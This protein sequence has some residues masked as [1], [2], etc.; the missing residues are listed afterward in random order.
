MAEAA[1][2]ALETERRL[3]QL[4]QRHGR[5]AAIQDDKV[6]GIADRHAV[7]HRI[8]QPRQQGRNHIEAG[9]QI[10]RTAELR[11]VGIEVRHADERANRRTA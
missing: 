4:G 10:A 7:I 11:N 8:H 1:A 2:A 6:G 5:I 3:R 9:A